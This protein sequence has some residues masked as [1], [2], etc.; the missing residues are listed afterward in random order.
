MSRRLFSQPISPCAR[1]FAGVAL[2]ILPGLLTAQVATTSQ[3]H[4]VRR[5][6]T[7]WGIAGQYLGDPVLWPEI[8]RLN[9]SVVED[10]H[11]IYPGEVLQLAAGAMSTPAVPSEDTPAPTVV[12][13]TPSVRVDSTP[14]A[15]DTAIVLVE[16]PD[17]AVTGILDLSAS[18][19]AP[20]DMSPLFGNGGRSREM[21]ATL[22]AY[23]QQPYRPLRRSEFHSSG[24][25][26]EGQELPFGHFHGPVAASQIAG[27]TSSSPNSLYSRV[28][29][30]PPSGGSYQV[31]DSLLII[32]IDR[33][34]D[35]YG[36]VI[37]PTGMVRVT[38]VSRAE[39]TAEVIAIYGAMQTGQSTL[40]VEQFPDPGE[41][42][43]VPISDGVEA[44]IIESRD[45]QIL[46]GPQD[47]VF[48]NKGRSDGVAVGDLFEIRRSPE[49]RPDGAM[50][51]PEV[52][53][54][55]QVVHVRDKT[56]TTRVLN[57]MAPNVPS[58]TGARQVA[59]LPS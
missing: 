19:S 6:D 27:M 39:N 34:L 45:E 20:T 50:T 28:A 30:T 33:R 16:V 4:T 10:P 41:V 57:V 42:R 5:G 21:E 15:V 54:V 49:A 11:W 13:E 9:T 18:D 17:T 35:R 14:A 31:G 25:L 36:D 26:S 43:P 8:Y 29:I 38:D 1:A 47:V 58:G 12:V 52:M 56:A 7:L 40:P 53:G 55:L 24:F 23:S 59:K 32:R 51:V 2:L 22:T 48:I 37:V 3:T 44:A 46:K